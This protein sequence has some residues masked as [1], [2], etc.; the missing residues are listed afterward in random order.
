[1]RPQ[2]GA[3][4]PF[5][6]PVGGQAFGRRTCCG[7]ERSDESTSLHSRLPGA[8]MGQP[9]KAE[10]ER[11]VLPRF[12]SISTAERP[13]CPNRPIRPDHLDQSVWSEIMR[14]R[15]ARYCTLAFA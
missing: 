9:V 8:W 10:A 7:G 3:D 15:R 2:A 14:L 12:R 4:R 5:D 1:M 11:L 13:L 6:I